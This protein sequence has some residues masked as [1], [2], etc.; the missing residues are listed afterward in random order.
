MPQEIEFCPFCGSEDIDSVIGR[1]T[2][3]RDDEMVMTHYGAR[4]N[5]CEEELD[6]YYD[7]KHGAISKP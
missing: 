7:P 2:L 3:Y 1:D 5:G 4:C 6:I